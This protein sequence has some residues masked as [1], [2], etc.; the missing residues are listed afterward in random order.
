MVQKYVETPLLLPRSSR[1]IRTPGDS[2]H[3]YLHCSRDVPRAGNIGL[4][5]RAR[6]R[7]RRGESD[8]GTR[9]A[10]GV[11][12]IGMSE[13]EI[14]A[15]LEAV[16]TEP[17]SS[18][19][20]PTSPPRSPEGLGDD[21]SSQSEG[22]TKHVDA[23]LGPFEDA[24]KF[25]IR[26]WVLVTGWSP[27]EAFVFDECYLRVCP[28]SFTLAESKLGDQGVHLTN[29]S[30]RRPVKTSGRRR[31]LGHT[32]R[33]SSASTTGLRAV[34][35]EGG[36]A[37]AHLSEDVPAQGPPGQRQNPRF[38]DECDAGEGVVGTQAELIQTLGELIGEGRVE[39]STRSREEDVRTR[40]ERLW[41][42]KVSPS[43][44]RV[45]GSTL[46]AAQ[47]YMRPRASSFQLFGFD[48]HLD[49]DLNP[50]ECW[51]LMAHSAESRDRRY[52]RD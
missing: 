44:D 6:E 22:A 52:V 7:R 32:R 30:V 37:L 21:M 36:G 51:I 33:P 34:S 40:G 17:P 25:D 26:T 19:G 42:N 12:A 46:L 2:R 41:R 47:P 11:E 50:C 9:K 38:R 5:N 14:A 8:Q 45:I 1:Q 3:T 23:N 49:C 13:I 29:L 24:R 27:L 39:S 31:R 28:Q 16:D 15:S 48:L 10:D 4:G 20:E 18:S 43:I 35:H